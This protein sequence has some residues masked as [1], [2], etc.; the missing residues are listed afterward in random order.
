MSTDAS[1]GVIA[2][3]R[4]EVRE[5]I[6]CFVDLRVRNR[7][8]RRAWKAREVQ[9]SL[10]RARPE[11]PDEVFSELPDEILDYK[12]LELH[13]SARRTN[14]PGVSGIWFRY[15]DA[16]DNL[17]FEVRQWRT[18][19]D[20]LMRALPNVSRWTDDKGTPAISWWTSKVARKLNAFA[21]LIGR[22]SDGD[23]PTSLDVAEFKRL[24]L[25]LAR[26]ERELRGV[27]SVAE[28]PATE[29]HRAASDP[30][31]NPEV[32]VKPTPR[33]HRLGDSRLPTL[34]YCSQALDAAER[35]I[36]A[37]AHAPNPDQGPLPADVQDQLHNAIRRVHHAF[38]NCQHDQLWRLEIQLNGKVLDLCRCLHG[39]NGCLQRLRW[40]HS[41]NTTHEDLP[42]QLK[43]I[44]ETREL[45]QELLVEFPEPSARPTEERHSPRVNAAP[46]LF[47]A[48]EGQI[49]PALIEGL[50]SVCGSPPITP[51]ES[52]LPPPSVTINVVAAPQ[53]ST[54]EGRDVQDVFTVP[55]LH[56][57]QYSIL[58]VLATRPRDCKTV[59]DLS[60]IGTVRNRETVGR[61]LRELAGFGLVHR[62]YGRRKGY[63]ITS[64]GIARAAEKP[65]T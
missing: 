13:K 56:A 28:A 54:R 41:E 61:L 44:A 32:P 47:T 30:L 43:T 62:P 5:A 4:P 29:S 2:L 27:I 26:R 12:A 21:G 3:W 17:T 10:Y 45:V 60:S 18:A 37:V 49:K 39:L 16:L 9:E 63:A 59:I 48:P 46:S 15:W 40:R 1:G 19:L 51:D 24:W 7:G 8:L 57:D 14:A 31:E 34:E 55:P 65:M 22:Y 58:K 20:A 42:F 11:E 23:T 50:Q 53:P 33:T 52:N 25:V 35:A 6:R 38:P 36:D 64:D